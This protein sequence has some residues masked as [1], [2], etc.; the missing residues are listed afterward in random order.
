MKFFLLFCLMFSM[1]NP[2]FGATTEENINQLERAIEGLTT[3]I[4]TAT[5]NK[6]AD[7]A[8]ALREQRSELQSQ[9]RA[10]KQQ[11][12]E[13]K[14][15]AEKDA[16]RA[17]AERQWES[18]PSDKKL[19]TAVEYGRFDLVKKVMETDPV[20]L[21]QNNT[22]CFFP[23]GDAAA[24]GHADIV[25]YLLQKGSP[26]VMRA[27]HFQ[28]LVSAMDA[29][30]ARKEDRTEILVLLK[31]HGATTADSRDASIP[32]AVVADGDEQ[33]D[34][35]LKE[36]YNLV[37]GQLAQGGS[38]LRALEDGHP[39]NLRWLLAN[40]AN[41]EEAALG[42]TALMAAV[43]SNNLEKVQVL[44]A[45]GADVNRH[46]MNYTSVLSYAEKRRDRVSAKKKIEME[47][48]ITYLKSKGATYSDKEKAQ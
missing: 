1:L 48:I 16:K 8:K 9:L 14:K 10:L 15:A 38:L 40:G 30:A 21:T 41:P 7:N 23:L 5:Q 44:V 34:K 35:L 42:R 20:N 46:G 3:Q 2:A 28:T 36:K 31:K 24:R 18:F 12:R 43:D 6:N 45:A 13:E 4:K 11:G 25:E 39:N 26:L 32:S 17:A 19:C 47:K 22:H 29:T 27:P 33:S 37:E